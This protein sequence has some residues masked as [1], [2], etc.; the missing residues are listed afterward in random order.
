MKIDNSLNN[1]NNTYFQKKENVTTQADR[2][3]KG[4]VSNGMVYAGD[5][6]LNT[7]PIMDKKSQA[8]K[9]AL[10]LI[11][12]QFK[13]DLDCDNSEANLNTKKA[14]I[15]DDVQNATNEINKLEDSK[16]ELKALYNVSEDSQEQKDTELLEKRILHPNDL[17][18]DEWEQ[19]NNMGPL[20]NYQKDAVQLSN[21]QAEWQKQVNN[22]ANSIQGINQSLA[23]IELEKLKTHPMVDQQEAASKIL[24]DASKEVVNSLVMEAKDKIDETMDENKDKVEKEQKEK[25]EQEKEDAAKKTDSSTTED[26][27]S[28]SSSTDNT[29]ASADSAVAISPSD[30]QRLVDTVSRVADKLKMLDDDIKGIVVDEQA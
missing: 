16:Q 29:N 8:Q 30:Q 18:S 4:G 27:S 5:L 19:L 25:E 20:T 24:E 12:D 6:N 15:A 3:A 2:K 11:I 21:L 26:T 14:E 17:T 1:S 13:S 7:N 10:K 9:K 23:S 22:G 28:S